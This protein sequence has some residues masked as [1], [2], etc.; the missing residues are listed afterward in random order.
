MGAA[1][2][3]TL[4]ALRRLEPEDGFVH[5]AKP[6][7]HDPP[8]PEGHDWFDQ[9]RSLE[10][11]A[12]GEVGRVELVAQA[13]RLGGSGDCVGGA[14]WAFRFRGESLTGSTRILRERPRS[15]DLIDAFGFIS[16]SV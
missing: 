7:V 2:R 15:G 16:T 9:V 11:V 6:P 14:G 13:V 5:G 3:A 8:A 1:L 4:R 12:R 10:P